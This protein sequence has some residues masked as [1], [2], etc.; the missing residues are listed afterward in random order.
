MS[1][2]ESILNKIADYLARRDHSRKEIETK[3]EQKKIFDKNEIQIAL[4]KAQAA[5]WF[6]P[7]DELAKRVHE[8]L[9]RRHK[10]HKYITQYLKEKGLP[11]TTF[12]ATDEKQSALYHLQKKFKNLDNLSYDDKQRALRSLAQKGFNQG[13]CF[14]I[15]NDVGILNNPDLD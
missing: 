7:E 3:L 1:S 12:S 9:V 2:K 11:P 15:L 4:Q 8:Q 10:S 6:T 5:G 14:E 13:I